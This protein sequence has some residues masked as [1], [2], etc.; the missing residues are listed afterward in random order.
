MIKKD[1]FKKNIL[2]LYGLAG[3]GMLGGGLFRPILPIFARRLGAPG[4]EVGLITSGYMLARAFTSVSIGRIMDRS[5]KRKQFIEIGFFIFF[6][7]TFLFF[8]SN[9]LFSLILIRFSQGICGGLIWPAAQVIVAE[10]AGKKFRTRAL[11]L[12]QIFGKGGML[13]SRAL[14]SIVLILT[15]N[16][17]LNELSSFRVVF[18][19]AGIILFMAFIESIMIPGNKKVKIEKRKGA[20]PYSIFI[21][22]F[23]FGAMFAL[24]PISFIYMNEQY[25]LAPTTIAVLLFVL[26]FIT[27][28]AIYSCSYLNDKI[29]FKRSIWIVIIPSFI[30][31]ICIPFTPSFAFFLVLYFILQISISSFIPLSRSYASSFN[32]DVGTNIGTLNMMTNLGAVV[33]PLIGGLVYDYLSGK[34]RIAGYSIIALLLIPAILFFLTLNYQNTKNRYIPQK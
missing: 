5:G 30:T 13:L 20:P 29:G 3:L 23:V 34:F 28:F 19:I 7:L 15:A 24:N 6:I 18:L 10:E 25:N 32:T 4:L 16:A 33:G 26:D 31:A 17:G 12:Y 21:L 14:L 22:G 27:I 2:F 1:L 9:S 11:S 8:F